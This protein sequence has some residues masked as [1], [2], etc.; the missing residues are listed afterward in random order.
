[1]KI[2]T[3]VRV[4]DSFYKEAKSVFRKFGL[5]FGD[6]VN[7]FIAKVAMEQ[8]IPFELSLPTEELEMRA[9]NINNKENI[10]IYET[11]NELFEE[12]GI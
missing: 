7:I 8:K 5:S 4:E 6:A 12:L 3:S 1:M 10:E 11:A 2:Q 9:K